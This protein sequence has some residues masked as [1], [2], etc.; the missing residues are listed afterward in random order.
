MWLKF[1]SPVSFYFYFIII[2]LATGKW[3]I[4][5]KARILLLESTALDW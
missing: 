2:I 4:T 1:I 3:K 5:Y